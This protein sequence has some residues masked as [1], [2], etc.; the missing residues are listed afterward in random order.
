MN[1][2]DYSHKNS[3]SFKSIGYL[4]PNSQH[5]A[6]LVLIVTDDK[7]NAHHSSLLSQL[8]SNTSSSVALGRYV[9]SN[10][11]SIIVDNFVGDGSSFVHRRYWWRRFRDIRIDPGCRTFEKSSSN[12][13]SLTTTTSGGARSYFQDFA[14]G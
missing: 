6:I 1:G 7:I 11:N 10:I 13:E 9:V 3:V 5:D 12:Q 8:P 4:A 14:K 2:R